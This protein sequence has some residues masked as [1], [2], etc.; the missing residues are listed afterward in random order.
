MSAVYEVERHRMVAEQI[1]G[2]GLRDPRL[3]AAFEAVPR[4][5]FVPDEYRDYSYEDRA[6]QIA[7]GQTISQP[8]MVAFMTHLLDLKGDERVL[9][10]GTGSG[11]QTAI[12]AHLANEV[13]TIEY[14]PELA[15]SAKILLT[16][17]GFDHVHFH[18]GDGSLGWP[19]AAPYH[20]I[21]VSAA[22]PTVPKPLLEQLS[23]EGRLVVPIGEAGE[24]VL[25]VWQRK[26]DEFESRTVIGVAFVPLRGKYGRQP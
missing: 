14:I 4:H 13:Y 7:A 18:I 21:I 5:L 17:L 15:G 22:A 16:T 12:L 19:E 23:Y 6:L 8:Y 9:D 2:R 25:Q 10:V 20:G 3:L 1:A 26:G 24:Q 11:Y